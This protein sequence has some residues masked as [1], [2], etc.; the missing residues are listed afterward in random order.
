M[1]TSPRSL[2]LLLCFA[3][4]AAASLLFVAHRPAGFLGGLT[5]E[6]VALGVSLAAH[7]TLGW[8]SEPIIFR[9][10]GYPAFVALLLRAANSVPRSLRAD[11]LEPALVVVC[12]GQAVLLSATTALLFSWLL[13]RVRTG[14][15]FAAALLFG[16]NAYSLI[17]VGL[18]HYDVL[19]LFLMVAGC[20]AL[21]AALKQA[22]R[23]VLAI[24]GAGILW[25]LT[26]LVRPLT[27]ALPPLVWLVLRGRGFHGRRRTLT[28]TS[29]VAGMTV[30]ILPWTAR[31]YAVTGRLIPVNAEF[32]IAFWGST[33]TKLRMDPN[34]YQ[35]R[36]LAAA[37]YAR[38]TGHD[39]DYWTHLRDNVR[40]E[41]SFREAALRNLRDQP[42]VYLH[43]AVRG[44]ATLN[45]QINTALV[46]VFQRIQATREAP[47]QAWFW[48]G[49]EG[50]RPESLSSRAVGSLFA[51]LALLSGYGVFTSAARRDPFL[52]IPGAV[53]LCVSLG[54]ALVYMDF[55][56]Y[57]LKLPFFCVFAALGLETLH[58][59]GARLTAA[60]RPVA[61][62]DVLTALL[63]ALCLAPTLAI[64]C[65]P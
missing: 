57:Y 48:A 55:M 42:D 60:G 39:Y 65:G 59:R 28:L 64:A 26:T 44:F 20:V 32:W 11:D 52:W 33:A 61:V 8:R 49:A 38:V 31:N 23:A 14:V 7:G 34:E 36:G 9:P 27:L 1:P 37:N 2:G 22:D 15:A 40:V 51:A 47:S 12:L 6:W 56:Y 35:W 30:A 21:V 5:D 17:L 41:A 45:L 43:N 53:Y 58:Q 3:S 50:E 62:A 54:H 4:L 63:V 29:F 16:L 10:P 19:H 18:M 24:G 25:G 13:H 46:S